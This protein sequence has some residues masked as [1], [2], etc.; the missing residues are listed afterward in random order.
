MDSF[1]WSNERR[2]NIFNEYGNDY[3]FTFLRIYIINLKEKAS[4]EVKCFHG[5][6]TLT[7][8]C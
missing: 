2:K 4:A 6:S 8:N 7:G 3:F 5:K 1:C